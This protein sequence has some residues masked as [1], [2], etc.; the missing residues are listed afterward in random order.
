MQPLL[1]DSVVLRQKLDTDIATPCLSSG[2]TGRAATS[3]GVKDY[4]AGLRE[5]LNQRLQNGHRLFRWVV[6]IARVFQIGRAHV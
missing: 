5:R 6:K 1:T 4:R 3:K 2:D